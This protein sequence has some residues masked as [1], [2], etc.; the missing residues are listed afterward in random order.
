MPGK[1][2]EHAF[3]DE[4]I[5]MLVGSSGWKEGQSS[6]YDRARA[7]YT[8]D[9]LGYV[10]E[11]RPDQWEKYVDRHGASAEE[12]F[13][14]LVERNLQ[15]KGT[16]DLLRKP[17]HDV[18]TVFELAQF[19]PSHFDNPETL[20]PYEKNRLRV[21]R[22]L[23]YSESN[24]NS[25]DLVLFLNGIPVAT[26][27][28]KTA[29]TQNI[30]KA[31]LQYKRDRLP[32]DAFSRKPEP[33]L[34]YQR[35]ALVHFA[36]GSSE[37]YMTT[38]L[39]GQNTVFLPFNQ[40]NGFHKGNPPNPEGY[41][42][43]YFWKET[44]QRENFLEILGRF[45]FYEKPEKDATRRLTAVKTRLIFP[46]YHQWRSVQNMVADSEQHGAGQRYLI[47]HSAGSGKSNTIAWTAYRL[48]SLYKNHAANDKVFDSVI[49]IT[50]RRVL[51][52][53]LQY[54]ISQIDHKAGMVAFVSDENRGEGTK[55][56]QLLSALLAKTSVVVVTIQTFPFALKIINENP[57]LSKGSYA[58]IAD[59]AHSSQSGNAAL[60]VRKMLT[61]ARNADVASNDS[62]ASQSASTGSEQARTGVEAITEDS[63]ED[64][65]ST[66]DLLLEAL[67]ARTIPK[68]IS[69]YAFT[70]T[71]KAKTLELF[72]RPGPEGKP[73]PFDVYTMQQAIEEGFILDVIKNYTTYGTAFKLHRKNEAIDDE[74]D[75]KKAKKRIFRWVHEHPDTI[76]MKSEIILEHFVNHI[77]NRLGGRARAMVVTSSRLEATR[78][79][80]A[81]QK[82]AAKKGL[83]NVGILVAFSGE[84][85]DP[86]SP[87]TKLTEASMNNDSAIKGM[88]LADAFKKDPY[89]IMVVANKFQTGFDQPLLCAMYVDKKISG[90]NAVQT[91]SRLN[92]AY[93]GKSDRDI[94]ILDFANDE[95]TI[96]QAFLP[97]FKDAQLSA[98]TDPNKVFE[99]MEKLAAYHIYTWQE[100]LDYAH[101]FFNKKSKQ[102]AL[103][104]VMETARARW[105]KLTEP[106]QDLFKKDLGTFVRLYDFLSQIIDYENTDLE[107]L[108]EFGKGLLPWLNRESV[109]EPVDLSNVDM[110]QLRVYRI[111]QRE[112]DLAAAE[113]GGEYSK[114]IDPV[115]EAGQG[116]P[117]PGDRERI[118]AILEQINELIMARLPGEINNADG[119]NFIQHTAD[120][121]ANDPDV[122]ENA[123]ANS[124]DQFKVGRFMDRLFPA[125]QENMASNEK[126]ARVLIDD[127]EVQKQVANL[128]SEMVYY[129]IRK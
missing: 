80:T 29:F 57:V 43:D 56:E 4:I 104:A 66:Q 47:Q 40:G 12:E 53:Q 76:A 70:A 93:P 97:Y 27:E 115:D 83:Q 72:G 116:L 128:L 73:V 122:R 68:N 105:L 14:D 38:E 51:D 65:A 39:K 126:I 127:E 25:I 87:D 106:E 63:E 52:H 8:E 78:F 45:L 92:R 124:L 7:L 114:Q 21:V 2:S 111:Q 30:E 91:L 15:K 31:I 98:T 59:E 13:L 5:E 6:G 79:K 34:T 61:A 32:I 95:E 110:N 75:S 81:L 64:I 58:V 67:K 113:K 50:D 9:L 36:A 49:V 54:T 84:V 100:V 82:F 35:G 18:N 109:D 33:L 16:L 55:A 108:R 22:Q 69:Y 118:S 20:I 125:I 96:Y 62:T 19:K 28:L 89:R 86:D 88:N 41:A 99:L 74:V 121:L 17:L 44:L 123:E 94:F 10:Q 85:N 37:I 101:A 11:T 26:I 71:P 119:R 3:E 23:Y 24:Q 77:Q 46:R 42:T 48:S 117:K 102:S 112:L 60:Q 129:M 103:N 1:L 107:A 120:R 90:I